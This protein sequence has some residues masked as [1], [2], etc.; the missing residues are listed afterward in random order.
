[1]PEAAPKPARRRRRWPWI[2]A[3]VLL[4]AFLL[5][6]PLLAPLVSRVAASQLANAIDGQAR[7]DA[8]SGGWFGDAQL[9]GLSAEASSG[10]L[11]SLDI[12]SVQ[13][14]YGL[15]IIKGELSALRTLTLDGVTATIDLRGGGT[16][17]DGVVPPVLEWLPRPLPHVICTGEI[18]LLL[19]DREVRLTDLRLTLRGDDVSLDVQVQVADAAAQHVVATF[20][21]HAV[22]SLR[23]E[24]PVVL[25][26][27]T[28]DTLELV[29]GS[30][31]Q[32]LT[33]S[34]HLGGGQLSLHA[35]PTNAR[36]VGENLDLAA[37]PPALTA[38]MPSG[39]GAL[40]GSLAGEVTAQ[41]SPQ[42]WQV[43]GS[44]RLQDLVV[45]GAGPFTLAG[46]WQLADDAI[47]LR[48]LTVDG[49]QMGQATI[50]G[51]V[52]SF[53]AG[54]A[55]AGT[56]R[57][58]LPDVRGWVPVGVWLPDEQVSLTTEVVVEGDVLAI[59]SARLVGAGVDLTA[60]GSVATT[61]WRLE[62]ADVAAR[63]DLATIAGV[64]P[65]AP[66][67][68]GVLRVRATG[69]LPFTNDPAAW[70]NLPSEV[71]V[72]GDGL[73]VS[74][75][76]LDQVRLDAHTGEGRV[77]VTH[78]DVTIAGIGVACTGEATWQNAGQD[79]T[80]RGTLATLA[81]RFPGVEATASAPCPV[82]IAGDRWSVGPLR[83]T[84]AA[85]ALNLEVRHQPGGGLLVV[86]VPQLDL[87]KIGVAGL[88]GTAT[89]GI[90]LQGDLSAPSGI[91]RLLSDDLQIGTRRARVDVQVAQDQHGLAF[92][93]GRIDAGDDGRITLGGTVPLR[94]GLTGV[95]LVADDGQPAS[96][97]AVIHDLSRWLPQF[98]AGSAQFN[99]HLGA[100]Q[101]AH[102]L[103]GR[104]VFSGVRP[105]PLTVAANVLRPVDLSV[106]AGTVDLHGSADG[107]A[108]TAAIQADDQPVL[109]GS[110]RSAG[111]WDAALWAGAW[112][113]RAIA[114]DFALD[115]LHLTRLAA[116]L[117]GVQHLAGT[118]TGT[119]TVAGTVSAPQ[120][121]G[122]LAMQGVEAKLA[123]D[124]PTLAEGVVQVELDGRTV[125][126]RQGSFTLGGAPVTMTGDLTL[127]DPP[128][129]AL[130][131]DGRNALL[132]QR[133][134]ARL[135]ADLA[136][137]IA[138]PLD[139][140]VVSGQ[141]VVTSALFSPDISLWQG[142]GRSSDGRL[143][144]FEFF[145]PP[146]STLRFDVQVRSAFTSAQD[147]V[148][149][150]TGLVRADCDLD[151]HLRGTGAAP[152]LNGRIVVRQGQVFLP[153]STLRLATGEIRF[154]DG[155]PFRPLLHAVATA[156][157]RRW[158]VTLQATGPLADPQIRASGDGLDQR[159]ALLLL[160]TGSTS[161]ELSGEEGQRAALGRL[162]T[163]IG[164]ETWDLLD[165]ED[166]PDAAPGVMDRLTL[167]FGR[168][169]SE[170]G[171]DTIEAQVELT[172][173]DVNPG[174]LL[175]GERDRWDDYNAGVILR[176][177]WG[178]EE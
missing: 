61:P 93:S 99:V 5:R 38:L 18:R 75:V 148:R 58:T 130:R 129:L 139:R 90:D 29:L 37:I 4:V 122:T 68:A 40:R 131:L 87:D 116:L 76:A 30:A 55:R 85:G 45:A 8:A 177:R 133:H 95:T 53:T 141:A 108:L 94:V 161:A 138:G 12:R 142:G 117:P 46:Q 106:F 96:L 9:S 114:G 21:R 137:S 98:E 88:A 10:P 171:K 2:V 176:F 109:T 27:A 35:D 78:G 7:I 103:S 25:G 64:V 50:D 105:R 19:P 33:G 146:M 159:D 107:M 163:W 152:E 54:R 154:P 92:T 104:L 149:V 51:L 43:A 143:V 36:V 16:A 140:V 110:L 6:G 52:W 136:L 145:T 66:N 82:L 178:G 166:D 44:A 172:E 134:D 73:M 91:L 153:F 121:R 125:H 41:R 65:G 77:Q 165:G 102:P 174:L 119:V 23:L 72:R 62:A 147:G 14:T 56:I 97:V 24:R 13:A 162:G 71:Q 32:R 100:P 113:E 83:L 79:T 17:W 132:V 74:A 63:L 169:V 164:R 144:P 60:E 15:G 111:A 167:E 135:R 175:F 70:L 127:D 151:L 126:L 34:L 28:L 20:K 84:S 81:L 112:R 155:D 48:H 157:V 57:A 47:N 80:W 150:A 67:L 42:G 59:R 160:T 49:P 118:A 158:R 89:I 22:D 168:Q 31:Q 101:D 124:V 173:P 156:Q 170:G 123:T 120:W 69:T 11:R 39:L 128:I 115:G 86:D 1:M 26:D 3:A